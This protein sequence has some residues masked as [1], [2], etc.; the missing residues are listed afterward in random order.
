MSGKTYSLLGALKCY[1]VNNKQCNTEFSVRVLLSF[2][3]GF[4]AT[5]HEG[6]QVSTFP[7]SCDLDGEMSS[8]KL[9]CLVALLTESG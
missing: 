3:G 9:M 6:G 1:A 4:M 5:T 2:I 8:A 7:L